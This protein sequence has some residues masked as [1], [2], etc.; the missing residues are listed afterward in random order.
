M[1][2]ARVK[3]MFDEYVVDLCEREADAMTTVYQFCE[4]D[5]DITEHR[6]LDE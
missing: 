5:G 4:W 2:A 3:E 1:P 6:V